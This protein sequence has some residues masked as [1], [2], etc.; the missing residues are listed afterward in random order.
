M[1]ENQ[2]NNKATNEEQSLQIGT[3]KIEDKSSLSIEKQEKKINS[4]STEP[5]E[6]YHE[7]V[8][9]IES[10]EKVDLS[11]KRKYGRTFPLVKF[12]G[13]PIILIGP[14]WNF[15]M[16]VYLPSLG[17]Y[18]IMIMLKKLS[19]LLKYIYI[20]YFIF[21]SINYV[22]LCFKNNGIP[23]DKTKEAINNP[24]DY[25]QCRYCNCIVHKDNPYIT[26]HCNIC[27][28]CVEN[29]DHHCPFATKCIGKGNKI[30]FILFLI[31]L[32]TFILL[33]IVYIFI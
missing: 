17:I 6:I 20:L 21:Y 15:F 29:F 30:Y 2:N 16:C 18:I 4:I 23:S 28:V 12:K 26:F 32:P 24:N 14:Q 13:E 7:D 11:L 9:N 10:I 25:L 19:I 22:L 27:E 31:T 5:S 33:N 1:F 8:N 3:S